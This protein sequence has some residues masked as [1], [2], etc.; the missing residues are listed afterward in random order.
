METVER[1]FENL[2][3]VIHKAAECEEAL[4]KIRAELRRRG[5]QIE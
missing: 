3:A 4:D 5:I 1:I 2:E